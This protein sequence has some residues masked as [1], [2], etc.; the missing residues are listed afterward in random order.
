M[1]P[2]HHTHFPRPQ[3]PHHI[4][5]ILSG[6][7]QRGCHWSIPVQ[8]MPGTS[9]GEGTTVSHLS[10]SSQ[11]HVE[12]HSAARQFKQADKHSLEV[13]PASAAPQTTGE[14]PTRHHVTAAPGGAN[15]T[16]TPPQGSS[17]RPQ[18]P[19]QCVQDCVG[20]IENCTASIVQFNE[21]IEASQAQ[22]QTR[23]EEHGDPLLVRKLIIPF[24]F[25]ILS[26]VCIVYLWRLCSVMIRQTPS[27]QV[28]G[29]RSDGIGLTIAF[30]VLWL[31]SIWS[32]V[33][34]ITT[35]PG[36]VKDHVSTSEAP[37][38]NAHPSFHNEQRPAMPSY[39]APIQDGSVT[40]IPPP[41]ISNP[42]DIAP[43]QSGSL[44]MSAHGHRASMSEAGHERSFQSC[45]SSYDQLEGIRPVR[46]S[47][48]S[49]RVL[50]GS[51]VQSASIPTSS[52][53]NGQ[54]SIEPSA[55][56][57]NPPVLP[58][59]ELGPNETGA[60]H[61]ASLPNASSN[62][63]DGRPDQRPSEPIEGP[64]DQSPSVPAGVDHFGSHDAHTQQMVAHSIPASSQVA[65]SPI[66]EPTRQ[67]QNNPPPL[68]P[69][70]LYCHR[71]QRIRPPRSHHCKRCGTCVL[72]MDHH[73]PWVGGCVGAHNQRF[74]FIFVLWVTLLELFTL[75]TSAVLLSRGVRSLGRGEPSAWRLDGY[76]ISILPISAVFSLFT[77]ALLFTHIFLVTHNLTTIEHLGVNRTKGREEVLMDRWFGFQSGSRMDPKARKTPLDSLHLKEK[78]QMRNRW[79]MEWGKLTKE[80][81]MWWIGGRDELVYQPPSSTVSGA[82]AQTSADPTIN[83]DLTDLEKQDATVSALTFKRRNPNGQQSATRRVKGRGAWLV[84][85]E[86]ALGRNVLGWMGEFLMDRCSNSL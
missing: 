73:C 7:H 26:W 25:V 34:L 31:M 56:E 18:P 49:L 30:C 64:I 8:T 3:P 37:R 61:D 86:L 67:P 36:Y 33:K 23:R 52:L 5:S 12:P 55:A 10:T 15:P 35:G 17:D 1:W 47:N 13:E 68:S 51:L 82:E 60:E 62:E 19:P 71:C 83:A 53:P 59:T 48:D 2:K 14:H 44:Y 54:T 16:V 66:P 4:H 65:F 77:T 20:S 46:S 79:D 76:L 6:Q 69:Q 21:R 22:A 28:L 38:P 63:V 50:P 72:K 24:V 70:S 78:R 85:A 39:P 11:T 41:S 45:R 27:G 42:I 43:S 81:N 40:A 29:S 74:F 32:Y 80:A 58:L 57:F 75:I 9:E 84:N